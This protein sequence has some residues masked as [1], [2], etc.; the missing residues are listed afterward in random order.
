M[1]DQSHRTVHLSIDEILAMAWVRKHTYV[2]LDCFRTDFFGSRALKPLLEKGMIWTDGEINPKVKL[3]P[4]GK[5]RLRTH[6]W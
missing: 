1:Y 6:K 2:D 3:T 5:Y 4:M